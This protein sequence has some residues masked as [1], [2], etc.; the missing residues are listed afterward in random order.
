MLHPGE[1]TTGRR[2]QAGKVAAKGVVHGDAIK[3]LN[4][5]SNGRCD[6]NF[7][8]D[9]WSLP[10]THQG[11]GNLIDLDGV[12]HEVEC[13]LLLAEPERLN[14]YG[15]RCLAIVHHEAREH[16]LLAGVVVRQIN[17]VL[18]VMQ[19]ILT[20]QV[21]RIGGLIGNA[22]AEQERG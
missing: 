12:R 7:E 13:D 4:I 17:D 6:P 21:Q 8:F 5:S 16:A 22:G 20:K 18:A 2:W 11:R 14:E 3:E 10:L 19:V 1:V 9:L 15:V